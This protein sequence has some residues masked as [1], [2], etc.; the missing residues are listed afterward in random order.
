MSKFNEEHFNDGSI[1]LEEK[2]L[3]NFWHE[4]I[5]NITLGFMFTIMIFNFLCLQYILPTLGAALL[6]I[7]FRGIRKENKALNIAWIFSIIN[8]IFHILNLIYINTSLSVN[9]KNTG[10]MALISTVFQL[11]FLI[12]FRKGFKNIFYRS[13]VLPKKDPVLGLIIWRILVVIFAITGLGQIW[14][15]SIPIIIYY[16]YIF[17]S[18]YKLSYDIEDI[19]YI[20]SKETKRLNNNQFLWTYMLICIFIV[21]VC[22][23]LSNH[24]KLDSNEVV[25]VKEY[26]TR[27]MLIDKGI[28]LEIIKDIDD[29][30]ISKFK[31]IINVEIFKEDLIFNS[32]LNNIRGGLDTHNNKSNGINLEATTIFIE[33]KNNDMY[34]IEYFD[35]G[36]EGPYWQDGFT[37][38][39][40]WPLE[41]INGKLLYESDGINYY[42]EIPRLK[43]N[44]VISTDIFGY[45]RQDNKITGVINYPYKSKDQRGYVFYKINISEGTI[46][47]ANIVNYIHYN[48]PFRIP[49]T[50][51]E[52]ENLMF[53]DNLRQHVTN[54]RTKIGIE[55]MSD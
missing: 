23:I 11:S 17:R 5:K 30:D 22:C 54:F 39:N 41:V 55:L 45:E 21:G 32:I 3:K 16:F 25:P 19:N 13:D 24:M 40:T 20:H 28:P 43:G 46:T 9:F 47:G 14:F 15:I 4:S 34:A 53:S 29:E 42:A 1:G 18:L 37:I 52:N 27:N 44:M 38:S 48:H 26:G 51:I 6:Y 10:I 33:L 7:G 31:D 35:W 36:E 50:E 12:I 2:H 8:M 49:Y